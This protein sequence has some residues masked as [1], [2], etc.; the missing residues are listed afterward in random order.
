MTYTYI[1]YKII[2]NNYNAVNMV[3]RNKSVRIKR[4]I[5]YHSAG[6]NQKAVSF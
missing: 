4:T 3:N 1:F 2:Q 6:K 5:I